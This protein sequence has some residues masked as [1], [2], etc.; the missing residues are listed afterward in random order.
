MGPTPDAIATTLT[1]LEPRF[2]RNEFID[3][4]LLGL[5]IGDLLFEC[6]IFTPFLPGF[7]MRIL[8]PSCL[9]GFAHPRRT[10]V[11]DRI[12][13]SVSSLSRIH[14]CSLSPK[15]SCTQSDSS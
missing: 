15:A 2:F 12:G 13:Q 10:K 1:R 5:N 3:A 8:I 11:S 14:T 4:S 7:P 9:Q 6:L